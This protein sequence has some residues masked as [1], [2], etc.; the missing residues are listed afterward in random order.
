MIR[1]IKNKEYVYKKRF[2]LFPRKIGNYF[3]WLSPY[4][5]TWDLHWCGVWEPIL[6]VSEEKVIDYIRKKKRA[7]NNC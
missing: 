1:E 4:Y 3:V 2:A 6:F 7:A 5:K